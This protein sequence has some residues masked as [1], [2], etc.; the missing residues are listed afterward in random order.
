MM[1]HTPPRTRLRPPLVLL[2]VAAAVALT[3][4]AAIVPMEP[5]PD[6][7][8]PEC[9]EMIVR[10]P[11]L[12]ADQEIRETNAQATGAWGQPAAVLLRCGVAPIGPTT[13]PCLN[14]NGIDWIE[15]VSDAPML[16]YQAYGRIP[17]TEIVIDSTRVAGSTASSPT[18]PMVSPAPSTGCSTLPAESPPA[19]AGPS[20]ATAMFSPWL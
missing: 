7:V 16:R 11:K 14:I 13:L 8:N 12:V 6:A 9:A 18:A 10:L 4:C 17:A 1:H 5:A 20:L 2:L 15:D 19:D 3:G